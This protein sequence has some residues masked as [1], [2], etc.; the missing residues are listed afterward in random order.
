[1][2]AFWVPPLLPDPRGHL[3]EMVFVV[4]YSI[5][6]CFP[7]ATKS[8]RGKPVFS[9]FPQG[10]GCGTEDAFRSIPEDVEEVG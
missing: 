2:A 7:C 4:I 10:G 8:G 9:I 3:S 6:P 5:L 1:M